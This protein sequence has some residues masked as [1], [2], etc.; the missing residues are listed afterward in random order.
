M[1]DILESDHTIDDKTVPERL[2]TR[3]GDPSLGGTTYSDTRETTRRPFQGRPITLKKIERTADPRGGSGAPAQHGNVLGD[4]DE[5]R[6]SITV[7]SVGDRSKTLYSDTADGH[8]TIPGGESS[9]TKAIRQRGKV[10]AAYERTEAV[11][12]EKSRE[13]TFEEK[14][15]ALKRRTPESL[16]Q[17][18]E[19]Q[20]SGPRVAPKPEAQS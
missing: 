8:S 5:S 6:R 13:R 18:D 20:V 2:I 9:T 15:A 1:T 3:S 14:L 12:A 17:R 19:N 16:V 10:V 11:V 4:G 7:E